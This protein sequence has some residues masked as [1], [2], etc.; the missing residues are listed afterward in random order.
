MLATFSSYRLAIVGRGSL[1]AGPPPTGR[2][3]KV[4]KWI[5]GG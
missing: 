3:P 2:H 1:K 4:V 5:C